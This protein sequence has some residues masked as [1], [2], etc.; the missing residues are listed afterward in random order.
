M[1][2]LHGIII[3]KGEVIQYMMLA[4]K[5]KWHCWNYSQNI[6]KAQK[7]KVRMDWQKFKSPAN[8][9]HLLQESLISSGLSSAPRERR[10]PSSQRLLA[11]SPG[12]CI[13]HSST[14]TYECVCVCLCETERRPFRRSSATRP[15]SCGP[16]RRPWSRRPDAR[17]GWRTGTCPCW[18]LRR[19]SR[20]CSALPSRSGL[21]SSRGGQTA[22]RSWGG[23]DYYQVHGFNAEHTN[24]KGT[25]PIQCRRR[26]LG[27]NSLALP[28]N[29]F[30]VGPQGHSLQEVVGH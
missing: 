27:E 1:N 26:A 16:T 30:K 11:F 25:Y 14:M 5:T 18:F 17:P 15:P 10:T 3:I 6:P 12:V 4:A 8:S 29:L 28:P 13:V 7:E 2:S 19:S 22:A 20:W 21:R 23:G 24:A 9:P